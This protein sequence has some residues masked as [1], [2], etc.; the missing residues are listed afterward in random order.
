MVKYLNALE[1]LILQQQLF[2]SYRAVPVTLT[3]PASPLCCGFTLNGG[4]GI[5]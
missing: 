1:H 2:E 3:D 5:F 4:K